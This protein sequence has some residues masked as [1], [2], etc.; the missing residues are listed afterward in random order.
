MSRK[1]EARDRILRAA[2]R[3][4]AEQGYAATTARAIAT[5]GGFAPGVIYYHFDDLEDLL[6]AAMRHTSDGRMAR[7][8]EQTADLHGLA[9]VLRVLR[10][11]YDEDAASGHIAAVQEMVA[12]AVAS[13]RLAEGVRAEV[14]RWEDF[15]EALLGRLLA[16]T[17]F[18]ALVPKRELAM[19]A[20]AFYLG[21]EMLT[22]LDGDRTRADAIFSSARALVEGGDP[23]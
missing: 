10:E 21:L 11:L 6:L 22:H 18:E 19:A 13:S 16:G 12:G 9:D 2:V 14:R 4:L 3:T 23:Y 20:L 5:T 8:T 1:A 17:P 15:T 7:Y